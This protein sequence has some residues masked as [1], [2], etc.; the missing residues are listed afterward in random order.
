[1]HVFFIKKAKKR[2]FL[3]KGTFFPFTF[4]LYTV[5]VY[6]PIANVYTYICIYI[7][8][9]KVN[10][11]VPFIEFARYLKPKKGIKA[12]SKLFSFFVPC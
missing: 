5:H 9:K 10:K 2:T 3:E 4:F 11:V 1:M 8:G 7:K 6:I 12:K